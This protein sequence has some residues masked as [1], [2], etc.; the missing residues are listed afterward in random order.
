MK[1]LSML[2]WE[3]DRLLSQACEQCLDKLHLKIILSAVR[4]KQMEIIREQ[5]R[6]AKG[7]KNG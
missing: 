2:Q 5:T 1:S 3:E 4:K 6:L 7:G